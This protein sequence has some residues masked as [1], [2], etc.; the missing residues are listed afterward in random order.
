M[1][2]LAL[3]IDL[4]TSGVRSAV[5]D[6]AGQVVAMARGSYGESAEDRRTPALWWAA[7]SDCLD[8]QAEA[9]RE[10]GRSMREV[11][12]LGVD[13]TSGSLLLADR[14]LVPVTR[15]LMYDDGGFVD[16][17]GRIAAVAPD[18]HITRGSGSALARALRLVDEDADGRARHLLHQAD[19]IAAR[20]LGYGGFA[21]VNNALKTGCDPAGGDWPD[22]VASLLPDGILPKL[23]PPG[24]AIG[25]M[26]AEVA[27]RFGLSQHAV[28]HAGTTDSIAAFLASAPATQG[29]A[30][31][32]LGTTLA[33]KLFSET[34]IDAPE[35]G[36]Y[37]HR[38]GAGWLVGGAS[39]TGGGVLRSFFSG[40][41]IEALSRQIDPMEESK[42]DYYPLLKPGERFPI[43]DPALPPRM[44]PRPADDATFLYGLLEG[45]A[46][47]ERLAYETLHQQGAPYPETIVTAGGGALNDVWLA[48]RTRVLGVPVKKAQK[49]EAAIGTARL[50][51]LG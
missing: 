17:A 38:I 21:D 26:S 45:I 33:V 7:V 10:A 6:P 12:R 46:R 23:L 49:T 48:I 16:E 9:L 8:R 50:V 27:Q 32:S 2:D 15:A 51:Q 28:V 39:N 42:L 20:F 14:D 36:L 13:G 41:E 24:A 30:V 37:A 43:N 44:S 5:I 31:T 22:W 3:G 35:C 1:T 25:Q 19:F 47:V 18:P 29:A 4:G 40:A 11:S 34:R